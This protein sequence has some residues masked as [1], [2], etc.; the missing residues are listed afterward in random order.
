[1]QN[2]RVVVSR[3]AVR[4]ITGFEIENTGKGGDE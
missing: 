3:V 4:K 1:M 2:V